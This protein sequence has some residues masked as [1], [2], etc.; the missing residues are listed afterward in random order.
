MKTKLL[1]LLLLVWLGVVYGQKKPKVEIPKKEEVKKVS[2][3]SVFSIIFK[4]DTIKTEKSSKEA[5]IN[6]PLQINI[7][8]RKEWVGYKL[9]I[10]IDY[11]KTTLPRSDY[12]LIDSV[13][14]FTELNSENIVNIRLKKDTIE[15]RDRFLF[16]SL[17]T[18][19]D[20][21]DVG[22]RNIGVNKKVVILVKSSKNKSTKLIDDYK[23][24][25][26]LGTNFDIVEG[27]SKANNLFFATNT[28]LPPIKG[29]NKVGFYFSLYGN[30]TMS[31]VDSTGNV[32]RTYKIESINADSHI[33]Y[34]SQNKLT[35]TRVSD[36]I[37]VHISP[38]FKFIK[39]SNENLNLFYAPS[40]E[41]IWRKS[42]LTREYTN[43][44]NLS[45]ETIPSSF[46]GTLIMDNVSRR[47][48]NEYVFNAGLMG[49]FLVYETKDFS[50]RI[51]AS[52]GYSSYF[53]PSNSVFSDEET[54][55]GRR[56]DVFFLGRAWITEATTGLTLQTEIM[57]TAIIPRPFFGVTLSKAFKLDKLGAILKPLT[58]R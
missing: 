38:L 39:S 35:V 14:N 25:S 45:S 49:L 34:T 46:P 1:L 10:E 43:P 31:D 52:T 17:K 40:L 22:K 19:N 44:S 24:L 30:R 6:I 18:Y 56:S 11:S 57:N 21:I 16:L 4:N 15:D 7:I 37:G 58:D 32:R 54:N 47:I 48:Q 8:D 36:N 9:K 50:F 3:K 5:Y 51:Q 2:D 28:Y 27:K 26:Y 13:F 55:V 33:I 23:M 53:Y 29:K 41:F 42:T 20:T 12:K